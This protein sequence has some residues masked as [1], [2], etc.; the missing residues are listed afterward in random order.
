MSTAI[1]DDPACEVPGLQKASDL[2]DPVLK[3][4]LEFL[5]KLAWHASATSKFNNLRNKEGA[6]G[7]DRTITAAG[8]VPELWRKLLFFCAAFAPASWPLWEWP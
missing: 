5:E 2:D 8:A 3:Q 7:D 6:T 1:E 4:E